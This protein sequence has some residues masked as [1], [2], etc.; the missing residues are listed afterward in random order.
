MAIV[1][2]ISP[3]DIATQG[4]IG[5]T[6]LSIA[7]QGFIV[8]LEEEI[9]DEVDR[10]VGGGKDYHAERRRKEHRE[11]QKQKR[12]TAT[13]Y[14]GDE[15]F[16]KTVVVKDIS[17]SLSDVGVEVSLDEQQKPIIKIILPTDEKA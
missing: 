3:I 16:T 4:F 14:I 11:K 1:Q 2:I 9:I 6:P 13:I 17:I 8:F 7:T 10:S 12:I 5:T 15:K